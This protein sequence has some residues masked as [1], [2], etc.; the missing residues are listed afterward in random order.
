MCYVLQQ[1]LNVRKK[2]VF[3]TV[4]NSVLRIIMK[5]Y[6]NKQILEAL[7]FL[8]VDIDRNSCL[9]ITFKIILFVN[10]YLFINFS[11]KNS[12]RDNTW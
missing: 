9:N 11:F 5:Y 12:L 8:S 4:K 1:L 6:R 10:F 3:I 7:L 2:Y